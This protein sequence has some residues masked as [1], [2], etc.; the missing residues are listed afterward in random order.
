MQN[1]VW[2][3][4]EDLAVVKAQGLHAN[5][6]SVV[7]SHAEVKVFLLFTTPANPDRKGCLDGLPG[8]QSS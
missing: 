8:V 2:M 7:D 4:A 3:A 1:A 6:E 5:V